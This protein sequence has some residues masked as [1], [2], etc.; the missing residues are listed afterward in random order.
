VTVANRPNACKDEARGCQGT[1]FDRRE[2]IKL[3]V[4]RAAAGLERDAMAV[5]FTIAGFDK[6]VPKDK[7]LAP[8]W[9]NSLTEWD[10]PTVY[11]G[12]GLKYIGMPVGG[13]CGGQLYL[14]G[15]GRPRV[16]DRSSKS[17]PPMSR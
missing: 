2:F 11:R 5:P 6:L 13:I 15:D 1:S 10:T 4:L 12:E 16:G 14:G 3:G 7:K 17:E 9:V 8:E